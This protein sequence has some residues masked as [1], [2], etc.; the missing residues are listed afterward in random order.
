LR[1]VEVSVRVPLEVCLDARFVFSRPGASLLHLYGLCQSLL[2]LLI[3]VEPIDDGVGKRQS[4]FDCPDE[5]VE[6]LIGRLE[7]APESVEVVRVDVVLAVVARNVHGE[8]GPVLSVC[9]YVLEDLGNALLDE[10]LPHISLRT[11]SFRTLAPAVVLARVVVVSL[12]V[13]SRPAHAVHALLA[14]AA[15][16]FTGEPVA[17]LVIIDVTG[18]VWAHPLVLFEPLLDFIERLLIDE[19]GHAA[20]DHDVGVSVRTEVAVVVKDV[21][22]GVDGETVAPNAPDPLRGK[23]VDDLC[24][25]LSVSVLSKDAL[26]DGSGV[27]VYLIPT[28]LTPSVSENAMAVALGGLCVVLH[29]AHGVD[30]ELR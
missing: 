10:V 4:L 9:E 14:F 17:R 21:A 20:L 13:F 11:P 24:H 6:G 30:A 12:T 7:L 5:I 18:S 28:I 2:A 16:E 1:V 29:P 3:L 25:G 15:V 23:R 19:L 27:G 22:Q 8:L 26:H